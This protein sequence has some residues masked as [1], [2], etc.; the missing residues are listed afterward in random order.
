[1]IDGEITT[2]GETF[3]DQNGQYSFSEVDGTYLL[4]ATANGFNQS[5][6]IELELPGDKINVDFELGQS[7]IQITPNTISAILNSG[8]QITEIMTITNTGNSPLTYSISATPSSSAAGLSSIASYGPE[9]HKPLGKGVI[10]TREGNTV[11]TSSGGPDNFGYSWKDS[12]AEGGPVYN[13]Q[14]ISSS[15][16]RMNVISNTLDNYEKI[17]LNFSFPYYGTD[18]DEVFVSS[19]GYITV[20]SGAWDWTNYPLPSSSAPSGQIAGF[21]D[22]FFSMLG[23]DIYYQL[24]DDKLIVQYNQVRY[25][26]GS[27]TATF[28]MVLESDGSI[29]FYYE[30]ISGESKSATVG[31]QNPD[32]NDGLTVVYNSDYVENGLAVSLA[33]RPI[34]LS[35]SPENGEVLPGESTTVSVNIDASGLNAGNYTSSLI[36]SNNSPASMDIEVPIS[37]E[38][39]AYRNLTVSPLSIDFGEVFKG[40]T[41]IKNLILT[42]NGNEIVTVN[43]FAVSNPAFAIDAVLPLSVPVG[44]SLSLP[45]LF[46]PLTF[47]D[48]EATISVISDAENE[49]EEISLN[50]VGIE[51]P[52]AVLSQD[53][54][55]FQITS[56]GVTTQASTLLNAGGNPLTFEISQISFGDTASFGQSSNVNISDKNI[57]SQKHEPDELIIAYKNGQSSLSNPSLLEN[58][59]LSVKRQLGL[60]IKPGSNMPSF[61]KSVYLLS[62][63]KGSDLSQIRQNLLQ[64]PNVDYVEPNYLV[65]EIGIPDDSAFS[66]STVC[67]TLDRQVEPRMQTLMRLK[68]GTSIPAMPTM[69]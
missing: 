53:N 8:Q 4:Q 15:G 68:L 61:S 28:Q 25:Y 54:L 36:V 19:N 29:T 65:S 26:E 35:Y 22:D 62:S 6:V 55:N 12:N 30:D 13:W 66:S 69:F 10:D 14:D 18:Y 43:E 38:V 41:E 27:G 63:K 1:M 57:F 44:E 51:P 17:Q 31:I 11:T 59:G 60:A 40:N 48:F 67:T 9:H 34:W 64:D 23:G 24:F 46:S 50:G 39:N 32:K 2:G 45:I 16:N 52:V 3:T 56:S 37:L 42:N 49:I 58:N 21:A 7:E 33:P 47:E 20:G 5:Q